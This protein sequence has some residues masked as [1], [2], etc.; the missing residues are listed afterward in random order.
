MMIDILCNK[1]RNICVRVQYVGSRRRIAMD[2]SDRLLMMMII[3][4]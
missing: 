4:T 1:S 2:N 3:I